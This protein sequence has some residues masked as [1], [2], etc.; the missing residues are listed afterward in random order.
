VKE[1]RTARTKQPKTKKITGLMLTHQTIQ[2]TE[3]QNTHHNRTMKLQKHPGAKS[4]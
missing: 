2:E 3:K 4:E 1:I